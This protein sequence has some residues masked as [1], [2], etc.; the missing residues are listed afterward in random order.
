VLEGPK[1]K[2]VYVV[3]EESKVEPRPVQVGAWSGD[4]W[5]IDSG[6]AAG[7]RVVVDGV[8]KIAP[9]ATVQVAATDAGSRV[10]DAKK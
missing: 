6:V 2:F 3:N 9:G 5:V 10:A 8:M 7:E 4:G 1:E